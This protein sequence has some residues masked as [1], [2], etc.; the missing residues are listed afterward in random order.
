MTTPLT[1]LRILDLSRG[2]AAGLA[3]MILADFGAEVLSVSRPGMTD[4][5]SQ[6]PSY[7][8][9][10]RGKNGISLDFD[11]KTDSEQFESLC[12]GADVL[13]C[14]WRAAALEKRGLD[15]LGSPF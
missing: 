8:M 12:A 7:P 1:G 3:T 6:S 10:N 9:W 11:N 13:I 2:P 14:N 4:P 5:L 15:Y